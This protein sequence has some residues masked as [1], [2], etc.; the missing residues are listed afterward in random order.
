VRFVPSDERPTG[1]SRIDTEAFRV[2]ESSIKKHYGVP[3]LPSTLTAATDSAFLRA[4][5]VSCYG[6]GP[7]LDREDM[8]RGYSAHGDQ[9]RILESELFR[10][11]RFQWDVVMELARAK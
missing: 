5:G 2:L 3:T 9:E 7:A 6:F 10:F 11:V 4:K 8:N 1:T